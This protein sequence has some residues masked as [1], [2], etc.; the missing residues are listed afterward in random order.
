MSD[1]GLTDLGSKQSTNES[2]A[3]T[4]VQQESENSSWVMGYS[5]T[6]QQIGFLSWTCFSPV[7]DLL[8]RVWNAELGSQWQ[9]LGIS[10][11]PG[12]LIKHFRGTG[13][14]FWVQMSSDCKCN[15]LQSYQEA[16]ARVESGC[17]ATSRIHW[18]DVTW[19]SQAAVRPHWYA[20]QGWPPWGDHICK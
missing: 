15:Y 14:S 3:W 11:S 2:K 18:S 19:V 7:N 4:H 20:K 16:A 13:L 8:I 10:R 17:V 6:R 9:G 5:G 1:C 12:A